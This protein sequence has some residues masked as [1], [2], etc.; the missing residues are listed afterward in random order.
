MAKLI[1]REETNL[2]WSDEEGDLRKKKGRGQPSTAI[3]PNEIDLKIQLEK[4]K[5]GGK[6]VSVIMSLPYNPKYFQ[7][8]TKDLKKICGTGGSF[9]ESSIEIQGDHR[10][11]LKVYLEKLGFKVKLTGG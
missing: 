6:T 8:L 5:R 11:K 1:K 9:K 10:D 3:I 4:N 2:L 7:K